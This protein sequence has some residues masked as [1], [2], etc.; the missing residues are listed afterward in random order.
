MK[1]NR[2]SIIGIGKYAKWE[3]S[4][5]KGRIFEYK[6]HMSC[7]ARK[8]LLLYLPDVTTTNVHDGTIY[9]ILVK[10]FII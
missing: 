10:S 2:S 7:S 3:F 9:E 1:Q 5:S 8:L 6:L 4:N